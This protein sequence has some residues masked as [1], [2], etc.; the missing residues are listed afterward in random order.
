MSGIDRRDNEL[1]YTVTNSVPCCPACNVAKAK[2][3]EAEFRAWIIAV[4]ANYV[5]AKPA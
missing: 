1:G 5:T 4:H 2:M 3:N